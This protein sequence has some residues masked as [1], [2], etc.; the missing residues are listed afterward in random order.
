MHDDEAAAWA[1]FAPIVSS[2]EADRI[3]SLVR[4][5]SMR[6]TPVAQD[7]SHPCGTACRRAKY[8]QCI[9]AAAH[10]W[11]CVYHGTT[12]RCYIDSC[13]TVHGVEAEVCVFTGNC[14]RQGGHIVGAVSE[15]S[16]DGAPTPEQREHSEE[17]QPDAEPPS[18]EELLRGPTREQQAEAAQRNQA[19]KTKRRDEQKRLLREVQ[20]SSVDMEVNP[21]RDIHSVRVGAVDARPH[22][23]HSGAPVHAASG[24]I[25]YRPVTRVVRKRTRRIP[26]EVREVLAR[27]VHGMLFDTNRRAA[28]WPSVREAA[29]SS[30]QGAARDVVA[31]TMVVLKSGRLAARNPPTLV[32][33]LALGFDALD[34]ARRLGDPLTGRSGAQIDAPPPTDDD[35]RVFMRQ[36]YVFYDALCAE[37]CGGV[38]DRAYFVTLVMYIATMFGD[39]VDVRAGGVVMWTHLPAFRMWAPT[40]MWHAVIA[41]FAERVSDLRG[42]ALDIGEKNLNE[43]LCT[44][45]N[46]GA[47]RVAAAVGAS[48]C[49][50]LRPVPP[51]AAPGPHA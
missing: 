30:S 9:D 49:G 45:T 34:G 38:R 50:V 12:H 3:D 26:K 14:V 7:L 2:K 6:F 18:P 4:A 25:V 10:L 16:D 32:E 21:W 40:H 41:S 31:R 48:V 11:G 22:R 27:T 28:A 33:L 24:A 35:V 5:W 17:P 51:D 47:S 19:K 36:F 13:T 39:G 29:V 44:L 46:D 23:I 37:G 42:K 20:K 8:V 43:M 1:V 15:G